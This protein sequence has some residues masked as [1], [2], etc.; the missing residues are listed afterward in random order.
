MTTK[1]SGT[2]AQ[3]ASTP[4]K[5]KEVKT[6]KQK[7]V[8]P[9]NDKVAQVEKLQAYFKDLEKNVKDRETLIRHREKVASCINS[10]DL[11][12]QLDGEIDPSQ[13]NAVV[14]IELKTGDS[15]SKGYKIDNPHLLREVLMF[16]DRK[17]SDKIDE[18]EINLQNA[19]I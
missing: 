7:D 17:L 12:N 2:A 4:Q 10:P 13:P 16:L 15:Y 8:K 9:I 14:G 3:G 19:A 5:A 11:V 18:V 6:T 1:K